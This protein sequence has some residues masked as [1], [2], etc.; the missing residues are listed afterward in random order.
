MS[1]II[2]IKIPDLGGADSVEI[3]EILIKAGD[4]VEKEQTLAVMESDKATMDLP[5]NEA[6]TIQ[7]VIFKVGDKVSQEL[8][9][10][11]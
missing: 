7:E 3:V 1:E 8:W 2:E 6:G 5:A 10:P 9:L 4:T 11:C